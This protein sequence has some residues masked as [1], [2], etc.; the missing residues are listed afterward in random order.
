MQ[1]TE[2]YPPTTKPERRGFYEVCVFDAGW[3]YEFRAWFDGYI[4]RDAPEGWAL[5][6]Q[7]QTWRGLTEE[8]KGIV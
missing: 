8:S 4:W 5:A 7:K 3:I 1:M 6:D 2:W